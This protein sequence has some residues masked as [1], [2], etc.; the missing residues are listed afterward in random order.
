MRRDEAG[1]TLI[2]IAVVLVVVALLSAAIFP[3]LGNVLQI[4]RSKGAAEEIASAVRLARQYA[5]TRGNPH[6]IQFSNSPNTVFTIYQD[7]GCTSIVPGHD[8][9]TISHEFAVVSPNNLSIVFNAVGNVTNFPPGN[10]SVTLGVDT[11]PSVCLSSVLVTLFG[12][13]RVTHG[14]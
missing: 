5:I 9:R 10:P 12:G 1:I 4:M 6:C 14:C 13:V 11:V 8:N 7:A 3:A 2:E